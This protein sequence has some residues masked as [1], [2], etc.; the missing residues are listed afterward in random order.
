ML[1]RVSCS[2]FVV[3]VAFAAGCTRSDVRT[4]LERTIC[5]VE[6]YYIP[7]IDDAVLPLLKKIT[8]D[9]LRTPQ[10]AMARFLVRTDQ[11]KAGL[12]VIWLEA[13]PTPNGVLI[14]NRETKYE[15]RIPFSA[16]YL[17]EN[18]RM[19][20]VHVL[21]RA[22]EL[23]DMK[24]KEWKDLYTHITDGKAEA[25]LT[26]D[27]KEVSNTVPVTIVRRGTT[28]PTSETQGR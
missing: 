20:A 15:K 22:V 2:A 18:R 8:P 11:Q 6:E 28:N 26:R 12:V 5:D 4:R 13:S 21:F 17:E 1:R 10:L 24:S 23:Y 25:V 3:F 14:R 19:S 9:D 27:G 16:A 7:D